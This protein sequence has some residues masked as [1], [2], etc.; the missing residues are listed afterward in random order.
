MTKHYFE[1]FIDW[2]TNS[3]ESNLFD[4]LDPLR[5]RVQV[6]KK[7]WAPGL[8]AGCEGMK[9]KVKSIDLNKRTFELEID[10][11]GKD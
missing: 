9:L 10:Y 8:F 7:D 4:S 6:H 2:L 1:E 3:K 11:D 5:F